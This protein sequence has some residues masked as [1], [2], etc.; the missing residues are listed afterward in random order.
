MMR[1]KEKNRARQPRIKTRYGI[2][3]WY[4]R[5]FV[6][7]SPDERRELARVQALEKGKR[8]QFACPFRSTPANQILCT[9]PGGVCS[10]RL[11]QLNEETERV[12][13]PTGE[14]GQLVTTCPHRFKQEGLIFTWIA[15]TLLG[16]LEPLIVGE[17]GFLEQETIS[18]RGNAKATDGEDVGR[19]DNVLVHPT[20]DPLHWTA[21]E[22]QAVYFSGP[23]MS[24]EFTAIRKSR[25]KGLLFPAATRRPDYR[26]SG[27]KRLMPQLQIKVPT[28][29]R[30]GKKMAV[31]V[32]RSFFAALGSM[33]DVGDISNCDIAWFVMDYDE[34]PGAFALKPAFVRMTTLE[35]AV[36]GLT[37]GNPVSLS[38]FEQRVRQ[39]LAE[40]YPG[41]GAK[42]NSGQ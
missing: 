10:L 31:V 35:R 5:S 6:R 15:E 13:A 37:G 38:L 3:E 21:L 4:G 23:S 39:K 12:S 1:G 22:I 41:V 14:G 8:P 42:P 29:R 20:R 9:K 16:C 27:P 28:L 36:E 26:S 19:I 24:S 40:K 11:Y 33:D 32:D 2:G 30:W 18:A 34:N 17:V 7:L 25:A